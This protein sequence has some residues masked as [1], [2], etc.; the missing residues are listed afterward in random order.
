MVLF[1]N[2][3][4]CKTIANELNVILTGGYIQKIQ[5]GENGE[6]LF[7]VYTGETYTIMLCVNPPYP[8]IYITRNHHGKA[9]ARNFTMYLRKHI[10][11]QK[12]TGVNSVQG[13]RIIIC[14]LKTANLPANCF[15]AAVM[16][17]CWITRKTFFTAWYRW[18]T[19]DLSLKYRK[20][21]L[22]YRMFK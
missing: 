2:Y 14:S 5:E 12:I 15:P 17:T 6:F 8:R 21:S 19:G 18:R 16:Y 7:T 4:E 11:G 3:K 13:E 9:D 1:M 10:A 22:R 20:F